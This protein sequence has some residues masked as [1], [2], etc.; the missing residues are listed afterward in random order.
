MA[1]VRA[2]DSAGRAAFW[3][4]GLNLFVLWNAGTLLGAVSG[5][6]ISDPATLGLDAAVPAAF[7][8]LL[9]PRLHESTTRLTAIA[10]AVL[11]VV[12]VPLVPPGVPVLAAGLVAVL[13]GLR[14]GAS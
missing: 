13:V 7:V 3:M 4:T 8:A 1:T 5:S 12:L 14:R 9:W 6:V 2:E 10:A 11:G